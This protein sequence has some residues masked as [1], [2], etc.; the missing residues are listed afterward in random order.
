[1]GSHGQNFGSTDRTILKRYSLLKGQRFKNYKNRFGTEIDISTSI[2]MY[3]R[4]VFSQ[5][6]ECTKFHGAFV[7]F[8]QVYLRLTVKCI[9]FIS[10]LILTCSCVVIHRI[11]VNFILNSRYA[12]FQFQAIEFYI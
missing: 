5:T 10:A 6:S 11:V 2:S 8:P 12:Y 4:L 7:T 1:M 9:S 3:F